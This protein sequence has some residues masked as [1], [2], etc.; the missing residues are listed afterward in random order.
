MTCVECGA[1]MGTASACTKCGA[2]VPGHL[3]KV[4]DRASQEDAAP[5]PPSPNPEPAD[6]GMRGGCLSGCL[7]CINLAAVLSLIPA[8]IYIIRGSGPGKYGTDYFSLHASVIWAVISAA[9]PAL[10]IIGFAAR[11]RVMR[12]RERRALASDA[13]EPLPENAD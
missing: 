13:L 11:Y 9:V 2:P 5:S 12:V 7:A 4:G 6:S 3:G 10:T 8:V 1:E